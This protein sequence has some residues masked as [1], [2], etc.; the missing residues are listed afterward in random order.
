[1]KTEVILINPSFDRSRMG[2][3]ARYVP[4]MLPLSLGFLAGYLIERGVR[5]TI[6]DEQLEY[7]SPQKIKDI[8]RNK[9]NIIV[10][11]SCLTAGAQRAY[12]LAG[13]IKDA[14]PGAL[15][16]YGGVHAT[17]LPEEAFERG[18]AD[19]VVCAEGEETLHELIQ[20]HEK[21]D[22]FEKVKGIFYR[23][24]GQ[25]INTAPRPVIEDLNTLP[26]FPY[27][28][29]EDNGAQY[30]FGNLISSRGCPFECIFC[31]QRSISGRRYRYRSA[32][33][34]LKELD[35]LIYTYGQ[36]NII[37]ND[38]NFV[39]S[40]QHVFDVCE[41]MIA[42]NYPDNI[43]FLAM[44][45]T[46]M[47]DGRMLELMKRAGFK[48]IVYGLET[49]SERLMAMIKKKATLADSRRAL[50]L[51]RQ[52]GLGSI[53][54]FILG[55]PTE[56]HEESLQTIKFAKSLPLDFTR[57]NLLVPYPGTEIYERIKKEGRNFKNDWNNFITV[58]GFGNVPLAYIPQGRTEKEMRRLQL[59]A[60]LTFY[61]RPRQLWM[62]LTRGFGSQLRLPP[63]LSL[64]GLVVYI[65]IILYLAVQFVKT[66]VAPRQR[67]VSAKG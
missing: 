9:E 59:W 14:S 46:D 65:R 28:L 67:L 51:T 40:R 55:L 42:R 43:S 24:D 10:G 3:F 58:A 64:Q 16:V 17:V 12:E 18:H 6:I 52:A 19:V 44:A 34:V 33:N 22:S 30:D 50:E 63:L 62:L 26:A 36:K 5:P 61:L 41:M 2:F 37:F 29:F 47:V 1:M 31:S 49:G 8:F 54:S 13:W 56:T 27:Y 21:G 48:N 39:V 25:V 57:F 23:R 60:N 32:Q 15:I 7:L 53:S 35:T 45:R 66:F 38:D 11:L 4:A 20:A